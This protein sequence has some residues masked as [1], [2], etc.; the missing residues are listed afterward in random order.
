MPA[1]RCHGL[2]R[3]FVR[4]PRPVSL[5]DGGT[6]PSR[7]GCARGD[8]TPFLAANQVIFQNFWSFLCFFVW[9]MF[10]VSCSFAAVLLLRGWRLS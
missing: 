2:V 7:R 3:C 8:V 9:L 1:M 10:R 6:G 4:L 5:S